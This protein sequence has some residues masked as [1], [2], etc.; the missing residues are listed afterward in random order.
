MTAIRLAAVVGLA[1]LAILVALLAADVR[2]WS[3]S[4]V[5]GDTT[6]AASPTRASWTPSTGLGGLAGDLLFVHDD[7]AVRRALQLFDA[8][9]RLQLRLDNAVAV[10]SV[11]AVAENALVAVARQPDPQ[12]VSQAETLLGITAF[13]GGAGTNAA[14]S[15]FSQAIRADPNNDDAKVDLELLLRMGAAHGKRSGSGEG[16]MNTGS[17]QGAEGEANGTGY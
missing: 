11:R 3:A 16:G 6:Y 12:R 17:R 8:A 7:L 10:E 5:A 1:A 2:S 13:A 15:D 4:I 14:A 9:S